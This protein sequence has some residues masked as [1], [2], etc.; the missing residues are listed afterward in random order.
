MLPKT[1]QIFGIS[2]RI[3]KSDRITVDGQNADGSI[4]YNVG[5]IE[6][7]DG[8][9]IEVERA[10]VLH[11]VMHAVFKG[12]GQGDYQHDESLLEAIA[13]GVVDVLRANPE[14]TKY[15]TETT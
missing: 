5:L 8:M 6:I 15:L 10:V 1:V 12:Q 11:E 14:L 7:V 3:E 9:P 4:T 2:Y 13:H